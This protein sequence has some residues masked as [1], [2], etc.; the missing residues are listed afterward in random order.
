MITRQ[1]TNANLQLIN[2]PLVTTLYYDDSDEENMTD[3]FKLPTLDKNSQKEWVEKVFSKIR[4]DQLASYVSLRLWMDKLGKTELQWEE[5]KNPVYNVANIY[6]HAHAD[7]QRSKAAKLKDDKATRLHEAMVNSFSIEDLK[8]VKNSKFANVSVKMDCL[9]TFEHMISYA[10]ETYGSNSFN[11]LQGRLSNFA[12]SAFPLP[13][14][15]DEV[16][17]LRKIDSLCDEY[18]ELNYNNVTDDAYKQLVMATMLQKL[19][20]TDTELRNHI[21]LKLSELAI[22]KSKPTYDELF[23]AIKKGYTIFTIMHGDRCVDTT[24]V[25]NKVDIT[26]KD[27]K[28]RKDSKPSKL[29]G[30][31]NGNC[32]LPNH[33]NHNIADCNTLKNIMK[34]MQAQLLFLQANA[35]PT[36]NTFKKPYVKKRFANI[37]EVTMDDLEAMESSQVLAYVSQVKNLMPEDELL[38]ALA[39]FESDDENGD[40]IANAYAMEY[41]SSD[42]EKA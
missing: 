13:T 20:L 18:R 42:D 16:I 9:L 31:A 21:K 28:R 14:S 33:G 19:E 1:T 15:T 39:T 38:P 11:V 5:D 37:A 25:A 26:R 35:K 3:V 36:D 29:S 17:Q 22:D 30:I 32:P 40:D 27:D 10:E 2:Q 34:F 8:N 12:T 4:K 24:A 6:D 41:A 7:Y 23:T